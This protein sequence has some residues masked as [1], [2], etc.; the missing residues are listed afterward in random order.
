MGKASGLIL[1]QP[2]GSFWSSHHLTKH[3]SNNRMVNKNCFWHKLNFAIYIYI[4]IHVH[5]SISFRNLFLGIEYSFT[6]CALFVRMKWKKDE[7]GNFSFRLSH[8]CL[9]TKTCNDQQVHSFQPSPSWNDKDSHQYFKIYNVNWEWQKH[10]LFRC[11]Q[12]NRF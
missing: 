5:V 11:S 8:N 2:Q 6:D 4:Y 3:K 1:Q 12:C 10:I 9:Q 7:E